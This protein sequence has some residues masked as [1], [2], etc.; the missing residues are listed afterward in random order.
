MTEGKPTVDRREFLALMGVT[1]AAGATG[2]ALAA[3]APAR[4]DVVW[5]AAFRSWVPEIF[6][7]L[8]D[9]PSHTTAVVIGSGFGGAVAA[10]RL[11]QAGIKTTVLERGSKWPN[12]PQREIFTGDDM[13]DGRGFWHRTSF[14]GVTQVP[15]PFTSFGGVLDCT[16]YPTIDV[17]RASAVG[18]GSVIFTGAMPVPPRHL[19]EQVFGGTVSYDE[20]TSRYYPRVQ[21]KLRLNTMPGD[22]YNSAPFAHSRE[23]DAQA[24]AAGFRP[25]KVDSIFKWSTVRGEMAGQTRASATA[26]RSNLGN[27]NGAKYDLNQNYLRQAK[28]TG[29][30]RIYPGHEVTSIGHDGKRYVVH[31][32]KI[33]P[34]GEVLR[35][36]T[37]TA[38]KLILAAGSVGTSELLVKGKA[39]GSLGRLNGHIGRGWGT[40]GDVALARGVTGIKATGQGVPCASQIRTVANG[41]PVTLQNWYV[42]GIPI[43]TG[44]LAS[45]GIVMD[46]TRGRFRATP[47]GGVTLSWP[48]GGNERA[49]AA[50][51][52]VNH[53]IA[54]RGESFMEYDFIGR[55]ANANFT[56]HPLGGAVLGRATDSYGRVHGYKDLLVVDGAA[57][58]GSTATANPALTITALAER[59]MDNYLGR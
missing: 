25:T 30:A 1:A 19:F 22:I 56:A 26:A 20:M 9:P 7:P 35:T 32:R 11:A 42:P 18:G 23:W 24:R 31:A 3:P 52:A 51:H 40:N 43:E 13:P 53:R 57:V 50:A 16:S 58:P 49:R 34:T 54:Q 39:S 46:P 37:L 44:T 2:A 28:A 47:G 59:A 4:G 17:W 29:R 10:L 38:D 45:L 6:Q 8:P 48:K 14:T 41:L 15:M 33:S 21:R 36:R 55:A 5:D 12:D 27:S